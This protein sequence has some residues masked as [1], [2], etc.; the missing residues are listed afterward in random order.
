[1]PKVYVDA[2]SSKTVAGRAA[3]KNSRPQFLGQ[4]DANGSLVFI[5]C[6]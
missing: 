4:D 6:Q 5:S 1:M 2:L 3:G